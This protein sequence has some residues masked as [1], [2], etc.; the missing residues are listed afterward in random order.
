[1]GL[2]P[3]NNSVKFY[4]K[5]LKRRMLRRAQ[6]SLPSVE[7]RRLILKQERAITQGAK[8]SLEGSSYQPL[9]IIFM[10]QNVDVNIQC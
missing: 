2:S 10:D 8:E 9:V 4:E 6:A 7:R 1:M 5:G 3:G